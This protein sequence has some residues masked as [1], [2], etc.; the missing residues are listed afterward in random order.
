MF[1]FMLSPLPAL[2]VCLNCYLLLTLSRYKQKGKKKHYPLTNHSS[3][4]TEKKQPI[5]SPHQPSP[6]KK[7]GTSSRRRG[8]EGRKKV[9]P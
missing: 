7:R 1:V 3:Y 5:V 2:R 6:Q 8:E 9:P 4:R